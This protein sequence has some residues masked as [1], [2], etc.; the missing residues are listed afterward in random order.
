MNQPKQNTKRVVTAGLAVVLSGLIVTILLVL[1]A[2]FSFH[3]TCSD[4][5][6]NYGTFS[7]SFAEY[8]GGFWF[9]PLFPFIVFGGLIIPVLALALYFAD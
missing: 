6:S 5:I 2:A 4:V 9:I 7:C 1:L 8:M 3:G